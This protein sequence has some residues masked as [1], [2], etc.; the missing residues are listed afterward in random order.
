MVS[1]TITFSKMFI[2][3]TTT[4]TC[5]GSTR[6]FATTIFP[7]TI[8]APPPPKSSPVKS[9]LWKSDQSCV[10]HLYLFHLP[11]HLLPQDH[12]PHDEVIEAWPNTLMEPIHAQPII[13]TIPFII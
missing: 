5:S 12:V 7:Y 13:V 6:A 4:I 9:L 10:L 11:P 3:S 8:T 1:I 2:S